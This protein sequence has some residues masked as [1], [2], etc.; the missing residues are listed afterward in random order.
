MLNNT[1]PQRS[2]TSC[3]FQTAFNLSSINRFNK[4]GVTI[5]VIYYKE[6][7]PDPKPS[8]IRVPRMKYFGATGK[9]SVSE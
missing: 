7:I 3:F 8:T 6:Y 1:F 9:S 4:K 2:L 5:K